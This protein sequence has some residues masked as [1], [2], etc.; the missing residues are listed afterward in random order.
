MNS[1]LFSLLKIE[2][3]KFFSSFN[4]KGKK[5]RQTPLLYIFLL[6]GLGALGMSFLYS[7]LFIAPFVKS[8]VDPSPAIN[9]FAGIT[10]MFIFMT[11]LNQARTIYIGE[12][13]DI[14]ATLPFR[15]REIV[16]AKII[17]LYLI[18]LSF[19]LLVMLPHGIMMIVIAHNITYFFI[20]ILLA[21]TIP[22]VPIALAIFIS[23]L[24]TMATSRFKS[25]NVVFTI[26]YTVFIVAIVAMTALFNNMKD[27]EAA[28]GF[29]NIGNVLKWVNPSY[30]LVELSF[31]GNWYL[32]LIYAAINVVVA[33]ISVLFVALLFDKLHEIVSSISMKK[34]YVRKELKSHSSTRSLMSLEFKRLVNSKLYFANSIMGSIMTIIGSLI[35]LISFSQA[36]NKASPE[37]I[38]PLNASIIPIFIVTSSLIVG[39]SNPTTGSINIEGK[40]FWLIKSLPIDYKKYMKVKLFFSWILTLPA[41]LIA[42]TI[43]VIFFHNDV[44]QIVFAY[45]IP[46]TYSILNSLIGLIVALHHPKL[47]WNNEAEAVK[48]SASVFIALMI[49]FGITT[50]LGGVLIAI[51]IALPDYG[52]IAY[53]AV[54]MVILIAIIPCSIY[55]NKNFSKK[56]FE[57]EDI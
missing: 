48:N 55:L 8:E 31:G 35:L 25:A 15:K 34:N 28:T 44:I 4:T 20:S 17:S 46:I 9:L 52:F 40:N 41:C 1:H 18:E 26:L 56:L 51:P 54:L 42:S 57:I 37:A 39:L 13:Y 29:S 2:I 45:L 3:L 53:I 10:S 22:I 27:A 21:F 49:N 14:L 38:G 30:Y 5:A 6:V 16:G 24:I 32:L 7:W 12:D 23:L 50:V 43:A 19:S 33:I 47:K 11:S 36:M